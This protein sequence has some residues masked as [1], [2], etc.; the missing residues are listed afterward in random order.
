[1]D[2]IKFI[3][4]H[5]VHR[6]KNFALRAPYKNYKDFQMGKICGLLLFDFD[7]ITC[8]FYISILLYFIVEEIYL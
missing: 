6:S 4:Q 5:N 3:I 1:M 2:Q 8:K 7:F